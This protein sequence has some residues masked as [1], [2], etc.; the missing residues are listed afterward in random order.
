ME[1]L[2]KAA[3]WLLDNLYNYMIPICLL[4]VW[5]F[6][7]CALE[8]RHIKRM[9][10][11][12][13]VFRSA[14]N[15]YKEIGTFIGLLIGSVLVCVLPLKILWGVVAVVLAVLGFKIGAKKGEEK[16]EFWRQVVEEIANSEDGEMLEEA[17]KLN[18]D[19]GALLDTLD[20]Y[21]DEEKA[22]VTETEPVVEES[23]EE[24]E[25]A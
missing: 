3:T 16:D 9:R 19:I 21:D 22:E 10:E 4:C 1:F 17:P 25:E 12:K 13:F 11:K 18:N 2:Q 14:R 8:L 24:K 6:F 5:R 7:V 20:V 23:T 15:Q